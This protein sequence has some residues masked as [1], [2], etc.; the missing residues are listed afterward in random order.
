MPSSVLVNTL[1]IYAQ[2][3]VVMIAAPLTCCCSAKDNVLKTIPSLIILKD[4][5]GRDN[6]LFKDNLA[7]HYYWCCLAN[8]AAMINV[9]RAE[10]CTVI[11][12]QILNGCSI[13]CSADD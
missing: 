7:L 6:L 1:S 3:S 2:V 12:K 9:A 5:E 10:S 8:R 4:K 11:C 13:S